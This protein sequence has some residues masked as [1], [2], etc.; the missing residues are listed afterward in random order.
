[1]ENDD[2]ALAHYGKKGMKWGVSTSG[3]ESTSSKSSRFRRPAQNVVVKQKP[4]KFV[5]T[6]GGKRQTASDDAVK[7][8]ASKQ[9]AK[10]STTD[11]LSTKQL[12]EA[13][14]RMNLEMQYSKLLKQND[15]RTRGQ[16]FLAKLTGRAKDPDLQKRAFRVAEAMNNNRPRHTKEPP[17]KRPIR[18]GINM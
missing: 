13:V 8:A 9:F 6:S 12:Q 5:R 3:V 1:M 11:A 15:R 7:T 2:D 16:R 17:M 14:T 10:K 18:I 4:G